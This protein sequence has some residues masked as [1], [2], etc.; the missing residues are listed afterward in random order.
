MYIPQASISLKISIFTA[1]NEV[2]GKVM[3]LHMSVILSTGEG[4]CIVLLHVWLPGPMFFPR[5]LFPGDLYP[6]EG[7]LSRGGVSVQGRVSVKGRGSL[8]RAKVSVQ[9]S[10][11]CPGMGLCPGE[12]FSVQGRGLCPR[13]GL[14]PGVGLCPGEGSVSGGSLSRGG[15]L[16][17]GEGVSVEGRGYLSM[18]R[19]SL[20][21]GGVSVQVWVSVQG[22]DLCLVGLCPGEG[23]VSGG[24]LSRG[25]SVAEIFVRETSLYGGKRMVCILLE[26]FLF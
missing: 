16:C 7:S 17:R 6:R 15:G 21:K 10:G 23:S 24:S 13:R 25:V 19:G 26:C 2:W 1:T 3:C 20:S 9:G 11:L 14:C 5:G 12:G 18:G 22:R 8:S 4:P